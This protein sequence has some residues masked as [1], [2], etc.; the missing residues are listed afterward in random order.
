MGSIEIVGLGPG[1]PGAV[2]TGALE[3]L[4][5]P[6]RRFLRTAVH[7]V[8]PWLTEQGISFES[9]DWAYQ[10]ADSFDQVYQAIAGVVIEAARAGDVVYAVPGHPRVA[11]RSVDLVLEAAGSAGIPTR[12]GPGASC[13]D[14]ICAAIGHDPARGLCVLDALAL[15]PSPPTAEGGL[16]IVLQVYERDVASD[17]KLWLMNWFDDERPVWAIRAA[18]VP[19]EERLEQMPLH[20]LDRRFAWDHLASIAWATPRTVG[21]PASIERLMNTV[22]RLRGPGGCPWDQ[23]QTHASLRPFV[24]EE[25]FEVAEAIDDGNPHK[26]RE[27]L[28]DLLLQVALHATIAQE[29]NDFDLAG[30]Q[31][32]IVDKLIRRHPHVFGGKPARNS[33]EVRERWRTLKEA[34]RGIPNSVHDAVPAALP[35]LM[36]ATRIGERA[37]GV[38]FDWTCLEE[39]WR[40]VGEEVAELEAA[41]RRGDAAAGADELG[42]C[43]FALCNVARF[44]KVDPEGALGAALAKFNRRFRAVERRATSAGLDLR[45]MTPERLE[46]LWQQAKR[47]EHEGGTL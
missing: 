21:G 39:A 33:A 1:A 31:D 25:A 3:A 18:G 42:D 47:E 5:R 14:A 27:E 15:P 38:G 19:G 24:V 41:W 4:R 20:E 40:K 23:E 35:A 28:G 36:R 26:L 6:V 45:R 8:V 34:E 22:V 11:E 9:L 37:A 13:V 46:A 10:Q 7:P 30:V 29:R 12:V 16:S 2:P 32:A 44:L 17:L 43:L